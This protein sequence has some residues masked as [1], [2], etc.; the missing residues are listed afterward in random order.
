MGRGACLRAGAGRY[1]P[2]V[3]LTKRQP[4]SDLTL[5]VSGAV[6]AVLTFA[7][8][9]SAASAGGFP[10]A[11]VA[12]MLLVSVD[13]GGGIEEIA[14]TGDANAPVLAR[15]SA[16]SGVAAATRGY[17]TPLCERLTDLPPPC[18]A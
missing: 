17:V 3:S 11:A 4:A 6:L 18:A 8:T 1:Y 7:A 14:A 15:S 2:D 12:G 5:R 13:A 16:H 9:V 10:P